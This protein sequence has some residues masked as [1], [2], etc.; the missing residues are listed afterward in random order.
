MNKRAMGTPDV[1]THTTFNYLRLL[2]TWNEENSLSAEFFSSH[3]SSKMFMKSSIFCLLNLMS[4]VF[5]WQR[6]K[7]VSRRRNHLLHI[8]SVTWFWVYFIYYS[9]YSST[10]HS[11]FWI[12]SFEP[13]FDTF[14]C[15]FFILYLQSIFIV[16]KCVS[17]VS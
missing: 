4:D 11:T 2:T 10:L 1:C 8:I 6:K 17:C 16:I 5:K 3:L 12:V 7:K 15:M 14:F 9:L 13:L